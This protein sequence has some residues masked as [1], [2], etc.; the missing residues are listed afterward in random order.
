MEM[1]RVIPQAYLHKECSLPV[2]CGKPFCGDKVIVFLIALRYFIIIPVKLAF[3]Y[4]RHDIFL[5]DA[6]CPVIHIKIQYRRIL[7]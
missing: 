2:P 4:L 7:N 1:G 5:A 6:R 3:A